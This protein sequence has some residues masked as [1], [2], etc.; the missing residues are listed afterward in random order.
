MLKRLLPIAIVLFVMLAAAGVF[1]I[2]SPV[3]VVTDPSF[4]LLYGST[5]TLLKQAE[6][7]ARL[8]RRVLGVRMAESAGFDV[9]AVMV[10]E[11]ARAPHAVVFPYRYAAAARRYQEDNPQTPTIILLGRMESDREESDREESGARVFRTDG[12]LDYYRAGLCAAVLGT[13]GGDVVPVYEDGQTTA[14]DEEA[15]AAGLSEGGSGSEPLY[16]APGAEYTAWQNVSSAVA[17]GLAVRLFEQNVTV[18]VLLFSWIDPERT[19]RSV[20]LV[21]DD[22]PWA[23]VLPAV[24]AVERGETGGSLPSAIAIPSGRI[25]DRETVEKVMKLIKKEYSR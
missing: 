11:A 25:T 6:T 1:M 10:K 15:F 12:E 17:V 24:R 18:P 22:S 4:N 8:W 13:G 3:L 2:R 19:S 20:K 16:L 14:A 5:R 7:S 23:Q 9:V 21:F